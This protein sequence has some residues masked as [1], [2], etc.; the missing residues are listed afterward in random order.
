MVINARYLIN[1]FDVYIATVFCVQVVRVFQIFFK[2]FM[3]RTFLNRE[4]MTKGQF[5]SF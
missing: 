4:I 1:R 3:I 5:Y 2:H